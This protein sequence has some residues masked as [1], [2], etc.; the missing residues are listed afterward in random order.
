MVRY[1]CDVCGDKAASAT[2]VDRYGLSLDLCEKHLFAFVNTAQQELAKNALGSDEAHLMVRA[3]MDALMTQK[4][5][6]L[7]QGPGEEAPIMRNN[8]TKGIHELHAIIQI[9]VN[10]EKAKE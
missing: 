8:P 5:R 2:K 1:T 4:G 3:F 6:E 7:F 10:T 9:F